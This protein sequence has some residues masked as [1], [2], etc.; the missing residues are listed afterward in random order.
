MSQYLLDTN[1]CIHFIKGEYDLENKIRKVGFYS[2]YLSEITIAELLYGVENSSIDRRSIN[3]QRVQ[4][5]RTAFSG[6]VLSIGEG[7]EEYTTQKAQLKGMG[8]RVE[9][10]DIFIGATSIVKNLTL[11]TRNT[12]DFVNMTGIVLENWIDS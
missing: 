3:F 4:N 11:V 7:L 5:L 8:R 10:L 6:R 9:D 2:C 12:K 1:I